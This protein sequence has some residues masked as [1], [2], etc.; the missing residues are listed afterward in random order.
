MHPIPGAICGGAI[1]QAGRDTIPDSKI[2][3]SQQ[4]ITAL[5]RM[6]V[7]ANGPGPDENTSMVIATAIAMGVYAREK[8]GK[9]QY[10]ETTML[11]ANSYANADDFFWF[12]G[13]PPREIPD[14]NG[15][16]L[17]ALYRLYMAEQGWIFLACPLEKE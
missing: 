7:R 9:S 16:G 6:F 4:E 12:D 5:S 17:N 15:Y 8:T 10:I 2:S 11:G 1:A 13:R 3:Y 14:T